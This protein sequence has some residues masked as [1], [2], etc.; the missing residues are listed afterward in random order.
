[1][2]NLRDR[3]TR[4]LGFLESLNSEGKMTKG[5]RGTK[6]TRQ[7]GS[8]LFCIYHTTHGASGGRNWEAKRMRASGTQS[9]I[10]SRGQ[11]KA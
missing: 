3:I 9:I 4:K 8:S 1:M 11:E 10:S 2:N 6:E 5:K 7:S